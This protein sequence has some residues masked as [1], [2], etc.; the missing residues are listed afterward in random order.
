MTIESGLATWALDKRHADQTRAALQQILARTGGCR[1]PVI[2]LVDRF[3]GVI[4][5]TDRKLIVGQ[6]DRNHMGLV[7]VERH[8]NLRAAAADAGRAEITLLDEHMFVHQIGCNG[9][10]R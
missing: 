5:D 10:N 9:R 8:G 7:R 3:A 4:A 6:F 1:K 2:E